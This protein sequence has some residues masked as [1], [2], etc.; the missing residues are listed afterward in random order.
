MKTYFRLISSKEKIINNDIDPD[1]QMKVKKENLDNEFIKAKRDHHVK[2]QLPRNE[3][4]DMPQKKKNSC[5]CCCFY[6]VIILI[7]LSI[8]FALFVFYGNFC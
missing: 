8:L 5:R 1:N 2:I 6:A 3:M 7:I 4:L